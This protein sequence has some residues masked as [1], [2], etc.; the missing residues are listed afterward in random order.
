MARIF[1]SYRRSDTAGHTG[2]LY[3]HL[4]AYFGHQQV[5]M[6]VSDIAPGEDFLEKIRAIIDWSQAVV[7]LIGPTWLTTTDTQGQ[8]RLDNPHDV[9]RLEIATALAQDKRV[10]PV[11]VGGAI[12]P[13]PHDLPADIAA[14]AYRNALTLTDER[15]LYDVQRLVAARS[16]LPPESIPL[17][18]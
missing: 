18:K 13:A 16:D 9:V 2:R 5:F 17:V 12:M 15:Y 11:L 6:D 1:I 14:L 7:V 3:D 8:R 4:D 10:I